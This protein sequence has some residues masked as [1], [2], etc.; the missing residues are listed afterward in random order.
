MDA[1]RLWDRDRAK[2]A[3]ATA[4]LQGLIA[5]GLIV[6]LATGAVRR[7]AGKPLAVFSLAPPPPTAAPPPPRVV[8]PPPRPAERQA[9]GGTAS[10]LRATPT[11]IAAPPPVIPLPPPIVAATNPSVGLDAALGRAP[12]RGPGT[13]AGGQGRGT[14][15]GI[16]D[17]R[18]PGSGAGEGG[19]P[20]RR[21]R[22]SLRNSDYPPDLGAAGIGGTVGV[23]YRVE[24]DGRVTGCIV[25]RSSGSRALDELTCDLIER[26][27]RY[28]PARDRSGRPVVSY[29]VENHSW[30]VEDLP[31]DGDRGLRER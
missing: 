18:G 6:G 10:N 23:E 1:R 7:P 11:E 20:P 31:R 12:V 15:G 26:R 24:L 25:T 22:G 3:I 19:T 21:I 16:G 5:Y 8:P 27:F 29:I 2:A 30:V 17:G 13:G 9:G 14:G 28:R 4:L